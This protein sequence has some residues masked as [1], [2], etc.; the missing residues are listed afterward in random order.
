MGLLIRLHLQFLSKRGVLAS[1]G[2]EPHH[3]LSGTP[4][5]ACIRSVIGIVQC[6]YYGSVRPV[7]MNCM[8]PHSMVTMVSNWIAVFPLAVISEHDMM[9]TPDAALPHRGSDSGG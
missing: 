6:V 1:L 3:R 2:E 9:M 8:S 5:I 7:R 4:K